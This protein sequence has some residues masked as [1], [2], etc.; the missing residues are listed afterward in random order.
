MLYLNCQLTEVFFHETFATAFINS[1][2]EN[3][4]AQ[5][6]FDRIEVIG[7]ISHQHIYFLTNNNTLLKL[8]MTCSDSVS[9]LGKPPAE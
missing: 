8:D 9:A 5:Q 3:A 4:I 2:T 7:V 6:Y 1:D